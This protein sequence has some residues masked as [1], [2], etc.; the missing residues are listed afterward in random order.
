MGGVSVTLPTLMFPLAVIRRKVR[1]GTGSESSISVEYCLR[2]DFLSGAF[3]LDS[4]GLLRTKLTVKRILVGYLTSKLVNRPTQS[5][6]A[7]VG[8]ELEIGDLGDLPVLQS[9]F[10][11]PGCTCVSF[12]HKKGEDAMMD[13]Q[14]LN[15]RWKHRKHPRQLGTCYY[16]TLLVY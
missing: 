7:N 5:D 8:R 4:W 2:T 11:F 1:Q 9:F 3:G 13:K 6:T 16:S 14:K 15:S 12:R 10:P